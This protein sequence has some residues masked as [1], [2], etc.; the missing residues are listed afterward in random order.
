[1]N[2][3][4]ELTCAELVELVTDYLEGALPVDDA[5]RFEEHLV[6][7]PGCTAHFDQ[8]RA[9]ID[10]AGRLREDDLAPELADELLHAF[11]GWKTAT[12]R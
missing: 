5:E 6:L 10:V 1:V 3:Q 11:R 8:M 2:L 9:A 7:C 4:R 12:E